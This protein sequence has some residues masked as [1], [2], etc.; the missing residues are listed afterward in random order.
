LDAISHLHGGTVNVVGVG[1]IVLQLLVPFVAGHT[2]R[3]WIGQWAERNRPILAITDRSSILLV[4]YT[5]F[6]AAV[7]Q[8]LWH[9]LPLSTLWLLSLVVATL[10]AAVLVMIAVASRL[11]GFDRAD[12][13]AA[14][15]C[16]SQKSLVSG[17]PIASVLFSGSTIGPILLPMML[18]Y[19]LQLVICACLARQYASELTAATMPIPAMA[20]GRRKTPQ[21]ARS[22]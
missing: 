17:M 2:L 1:Q 11:L 10:L 3:P 21:V 9:Q 7:I 16:G 13:V 6:S 4:A 18:Y 8:G 15:F 14:M 19:P 12:E 20:L 5:A 22:Q